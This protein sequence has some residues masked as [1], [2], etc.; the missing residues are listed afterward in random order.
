MRRP[1]RSGP[2]SGNLDHLVRF[3][4]PFKFSLPGRRFGL[5]S[6]RTRLGSAVLQLQTG[7]PL[8]LTPA[9]LAEAADVL[10]GLTLDRRVLQNR[11]QTE[12]FRGP[13]LTG[14]GRGLMVNKN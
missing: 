6:P 4:S 1:P 13:A 8:V 5:V 3:V 9:L 14:G 11:K 10:Q 2:E 12:P 7:H